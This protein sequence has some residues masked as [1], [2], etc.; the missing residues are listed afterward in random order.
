MACDRIGAERLNAYCERVK[1]AF[2]AYMHGGWAHPIPRTASSIDEGPETELDSEGEDGS[3][4]VMGLGLGERGRSKERGDGS[5]V[6]NERP[7]KY[8]TGATMLMREEGG[9]PFADTVMDDED[10]EF[11]RFENGGELLRIDLDDVQETDETTSSNE[12]KDTRWVLGYV[13][14]SQLTSISCPV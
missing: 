2:E 7:E 12:D 4:A 13:Y 9:D 8:E 6:R 5:V 14:D 1:E 3:V 11:E 10:D